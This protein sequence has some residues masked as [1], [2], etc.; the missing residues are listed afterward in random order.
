MPSTPKDNRERLD[1]MLRRKSSFGDCHVPDVLH[2][3][4]VNGTESC[5]DGSVIREEEESDEN[6][7]AEFEQYPLVAIPKGQ[8]HLALKSKVSQ[9]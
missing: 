7:I 2:I 5:E 9:N 8:V 6:F 3:P 4:Q 1:V